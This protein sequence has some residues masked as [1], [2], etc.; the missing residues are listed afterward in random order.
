MPS[1]FSNFSLQGSLVDVSLM[2]IFPAAAHLKLSKEKG[3]LS[4]V[5]RAISLAVLVFGILVMIT[6]LGSAIYHAIVTQSEHVKLYCNEERQLQGWGD[7]L[8]PSEGFRDLPYSM[9]GLASSCDC[10]T[11]F[12]VNQPTACNISSQ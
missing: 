8:C 12:R 6:G 1:T 3:G 4:W 9:V 11:V 2:L 5:K 10:A 7:T